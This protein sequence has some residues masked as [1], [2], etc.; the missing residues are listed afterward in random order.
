MGLKHVLNCILKQG[1]LLNQGLS[2]HAGKTPVNFSE[3]FI[4]VKTA[5]LDL[6]A[7]ILNSP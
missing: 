6:T 2:P 5:R 1:C 4:C 3:S 7:Q